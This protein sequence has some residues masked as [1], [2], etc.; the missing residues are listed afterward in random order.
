[1]TQEDVIRMAIEAGWKDLRNFDSEMHEFLVLGSFKN[2]EHFANLV[3][4]ATATKE[5]QRLCD[6]F[7]KLEDK[8][9]TVR[10]KMYLSGVQAVIRAR[11]TLVE[12]G[13]Q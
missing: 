1:M 5:I 10:D 6:Y 4:Q 8:A 12:R 11:G 13:E 3:E 9:E 2:L 7:Q